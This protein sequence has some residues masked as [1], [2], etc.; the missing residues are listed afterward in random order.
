MVHANQIVVVHSNLTLIIN[1]GQKINLHVIELFIVIKNQM[2]KRITRCKFTPFN[3]SC[4]QRKC[5]TRYYIGKVLKSKGCRVL[6]KNC[7]LKRRKIC[8]RKFTKYGCSHIECRNTYL[9]NG[10][11]VSTGVS[12]NSKFSCPI[13]TKRKCETIKSKKKMEDVILLNVVENL[14]DLENLLD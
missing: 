5:C 11:I 3:V 9:R 2:K 13:I 1:H 12:R 6:Y 10:K 4:R 7:P 8:Q 14:L